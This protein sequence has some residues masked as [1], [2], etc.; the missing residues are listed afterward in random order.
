[1]PFITPKT[2]WTSVDGVRDADLNRIE[3]NIHEL[4]NTAQVRSTYTVYVSTSG[5]D[6]TGA[7]TEASPYRTITKALS[8]IPRIIGDKVV[9]LYIATG[10]YNESVVISGFT[11]V[12]AINTAGAGPV[13]VSSL[14]IDGCNVTHTGAQL[15]ATNGV[16]LTNGATFRGNAAMYVGSSAIGYAVKTGSTFI[17]LNTITASNATSAGLEVSEQG[18]A[19]VSTI[20]GTGNTVGIRADTGG[21][22]CYGSMVMS[23]STLRVTNTG[24]RIFSGPQSGVGGGL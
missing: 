7:G 11:G 12:L 24:G 5:S 4:Y 19:Y 8:T 6:D 16:V 17:V 13:T 15:N 18:Q 1:M 20:G 3:G 2:D 9:T 14:T 21:V 23:A 10:T 22:A